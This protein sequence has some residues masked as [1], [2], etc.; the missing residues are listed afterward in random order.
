MT[1]R[2]TVGVPAL[3]AGVDEHLP[4]DISENRRAVIW[5]WA[6]RR[7]PREWQWTKP[8]FQARRPDLPAD[9]TDPSTWASF[10]EALAVVA[11]GKAHGVGIVLGDGLVG[12]DLD[13]VRDVATGAIEA[14]ATAIV[15]ALDSY[16]EA[17]PSGTGVHVLVRGSL[18]PGGRR[19]GS[20]EMYASN[21]YFTVTGEH[22]DGTPTTIEERTEALAAL[23]ARTFGAN[24]KPSLQFCRPEGPIERAD[25]GLLERAHAARNGA[26]F[27]AL[28]GGD[29]SG[30]R[31]QSEG[32]LA[33][34]NLLAL[35]TDGDAVRIDRLFCRSGLMRPKWGERRGGQ[36]YGERTIATAIAGRR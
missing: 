12:V 35:W 36:T 30:Y 25:A 27:A 9:V 31:S 24:R 19:T 21:R 22:L 2:P 34:C 5:R 17:S 3:A 23:H 32:D 10:A 15:L 14:E 7:A 20:L 28:W 29:W 18:P 33:L 1:A 11:A 6:R 26:K 13:D 4:L 8:P 16:T